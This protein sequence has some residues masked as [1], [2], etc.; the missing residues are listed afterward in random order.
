M[1]ALGEMLRGCTI[2]TVSDRGV[3]YIT[4]GAPTAAAANWLHDHFELL[5]ASPA[6]PTVPNATSMPCIACRKP[7]EDAMPDPSQGNQPY[8][9]LEFTSRGHYGSTIFD[10][11]PGALVVNVCDECVTVASRDGLV[12]R[13]TFFGRPH[14]A[15]AHPDEA[16]IS[17][18]ASAGEAR[19]DATPKS[20]AAEGEH[21]VGEAE[22]PNPSPASI[23]KKKEITWVE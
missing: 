1:T 12:R 23:R 2:A 8:P 10:M 18:R 21:A 22:T 4:V 15:R 20:G 19:S 6:K 14:E 17:P 7:L 9:G 3:F 16:W 13:R 11:E 5:A